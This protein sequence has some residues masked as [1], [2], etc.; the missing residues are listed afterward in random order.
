MKALI[1]RAMNARVSVNGE[2]ISS[3]GQGACVFIGINQDDTMKDVE[4]MAKKLLSIKLFEDNEKKWKKSIVD[5]EFEI[6][7][8]SQFTLYATWK[9]NHPDYHKAMPGEKSKELYDKLI[10][11]MRKQYKPDMIKDGVFG[12]YMQ[13]TLQNDG[14][15]TLELES[16]VQQE[17]VKQKKTNNEAKVSNG[18]VADTH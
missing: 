4:F 13:V 8:I 17:K 12:A 5:K 9:G 7:C 11:L 3:I 18:D 2:V 6:L 1:Q 15:V 10:E 16:P 14:P